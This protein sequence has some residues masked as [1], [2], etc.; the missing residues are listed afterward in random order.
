MN[1]MWR[2][3]RPTLEDVRRHLDHQR[4]LPF[5]YGAV[6]GTRTGQAP[7]GFDRDHNREQ[8]GAGAAAFAAACDAIRGWKMFPA[9]LAWVEPP[10]VPIAAGELVGMVAHALGLWWLN[11]TRIVYVIDEPRRFGFA[12]GTLPGHV[13]RG[14]ERFSV[15]WLDDDTVWYDLLAFSRPRYWGARLAR[16]V[17]RML[18]R[19]FVRL[20]KAA[21]RGAAATA[22]VRSPDPAA[23][24][25][26]GSRSDRRP[27]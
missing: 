26:T 25:S 20:S 12:Y 24:G 17:A 14:E 3:S 6:G 23:S 11:A 21:M 22:L 16:P 8:L 18:Q 1:R 13:E 9:P 2:L 15:E 19:R 7:E 4:G 5:S 10:G 27:A